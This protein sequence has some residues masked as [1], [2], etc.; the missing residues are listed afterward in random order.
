MHKAQRGFTLIELV[1]VIVILGVLAAAALPRFSDLTREARIASLNGLAGGLHGAASI[2]KATQLAQSLSAGAPVTIETETIT[3]TGRYPT[4]D[5]TGIERALSDFTGFTHNG[6]GV[7]T[8]TAGC[9][10]TYAN[11]GG[12]TYSVTLDSS[13]C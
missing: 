11:T 7:F 5:S 1:L 3:M 8:L 2:A 13:S 10:V 4:A 12:G 6:A 9:T